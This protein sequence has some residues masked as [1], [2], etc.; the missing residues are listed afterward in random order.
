MTSV[1]TNGWWCWL[2]WQGWAGVS[3]VV[4]LLALAAVIVF[5]V[6]AFVASRSPSRL[7]D[8]SPEEITEVS[9]G[10]HKGTL[11]LSAVGSQPLYEVDVDMVH[12]DA[13]PIGLIATVPLVEVGAPPIRIPFL[14]TEPLRDCW[15]VIRWW[16]PSR[17][18]SVLGA[19]RFS[20]VFTDAPTYWWVRW[21]FAWLPH[22]FSGRW[23]AQR[24]EQSRDSVD[25]SAPNPHRERGF[26]REG[27]RD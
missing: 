17:S 11:L 21:R 27:T 8:V 26:R 4:A 5:G 23:R 1:C 13:R 19:M 6:V 22:K 25:V 15:V 10:R 2:T 20:L 9:G 18:G 3:G 24:S 7:L 14:V 12:S 16:E